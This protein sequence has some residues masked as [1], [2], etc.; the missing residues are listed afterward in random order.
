MH[1]SS[2]I[3]NHLS[4]TAKRHVRHT[5]HASVVAAECSYGEISLTKKPCTVSPSQRLNIE[6][7]DARQCSRQD[8][9]R[10]IPSCICP[11]YQL[12]GVA[13]F[14]TTLHSKL[15]WNYHLREIF[16]NTIV[17]ER[18]CRVVNPEKRFGKGERDTFFK[19]RRKSWQNVGTCRSNNKR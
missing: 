11:Q 7:A 16:R 12:P 4:A 9:E 6:E 14:D 1:G 13:A 17:E 5:E 3:E 18:L 8:I 15:W 10:L 19:V 2:R